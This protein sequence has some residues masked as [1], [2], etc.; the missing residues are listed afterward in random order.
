[1]DIIEYD[2]H[3]ITIFDGDITTPPLDGFVISGAFGTH[4]LSYVDNGKIF[5]LNHAPYK[6][7]RLTIEALKILLDDSPTWTR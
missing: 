4:I 7:L 1:M 3:L 2:G 5:P 6:N